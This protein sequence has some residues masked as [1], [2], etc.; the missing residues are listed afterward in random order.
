MSENG[1]EA[2]FRESTRKIRARQVYPFLIVFGTVLA[3]IVAG[4]G[5]LLLDLKTDV[6]VGIVTTAG[7][8]LFGGSILRLLSSRCPRCNNA[9]FFRG[10]SA[11]PFAGSCLN[12]GLL[13]K[14]RESK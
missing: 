11:N 5:T 6:P 2:E 7:F 13:L 8:L 12:C 14:E 1:L 10:I 3:F 4:A 9:V